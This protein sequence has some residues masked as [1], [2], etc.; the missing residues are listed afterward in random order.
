MSTRST[1]IRLIAGDDAG[2][3]AVHLARD[4][5]AFARWEPARS[6]D[7]YTAGGQQRR[8]ERL[9]SAHHDGAIWPGV[10]LVDGRVAGQVT[11]KPARSSR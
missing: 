11:V 6:E 9:L 4:A 8:I 1:G 7:F 5:A 2:A 3:L 10:V